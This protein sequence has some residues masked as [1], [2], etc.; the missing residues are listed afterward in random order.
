MQPDAQF[1]ATLPADSTMLGAIVDTSGSV[2]LGLDRE[3]RIFAWN[4]AAELLYQTPRAQAIG[5]DCVGTFIA[6]E[7]R[8][9]F[10]A[11]IREVLAGKRTLNFEDDSLLPDGT[12][13]TLLWNVTRVLDTAGTPVGIVATGQ[14]ITERKEAEER[15]RLVFEYATDGLLIADESGVLDCNPAAVAML[16]LTTKEQLIGRKP[17]EFSPT[18]QPDGTPSGEKSREL[19]AVTLL[20]GGHTFDWVHQRPDGTEIPVEVSVQ[21]ARMNNRRVSIVSWRDQ[22]RRLEIERERAAVEQRLHVAQKMEAVGQLAG[23]VAHDFN[24]LLTALRNSIQLAIHEV[25][26]DFAIHSDLELALRTTERATGLTGQ[27][28]ACSRQQGRDV[29]RHNLSQVVHE[30]LPLLRTALPPSVT[31]HVAVE[32]TRVDVT[33]DRGQI[34]QVLLHLVLNARDAM[35]QGGELTIGLQREPDAAHATL[36]VR[37]TG[38]GMDAAVQARMFEPFFTTKPVGAGT[39]LGLAVVYGVVLQSGGSIR[40]ESAPGDGTA[41]HITLPLAAAGPS[42]PAAVATAPSKK[43]V[44]LLVDDDRAVRST[45]RRLLERSGFTVVDVESGAEALER[46]AESPEQFDVLLSDIRMPGM[47]GVQLAQSIR[48]LSAGFPIVFISGYD[49]A[50]DHHLDAMTAVQ[51]VAKPFESERLFATLRQAIADRA[52]VS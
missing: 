40:V 39:G 25:P 8:D 21:Y 1:M 31:M 34:E 2:I 43:A 4:R 3:H 24:N 48:A 14:D 51:L 49:E 27:L 42:I 5:M 45:T 26:R 38:S 29:Q 9:A 35:P 17:A 16:G 50:G 10:R 52:P 23:G 36:T 37:D 20:Q 28:L 7:H 30:L 33:V 32:S 46:F 15:F 6:P 13:R 44:V 11:D 41:L 22:S 19:G 12:R 47:G 18:L